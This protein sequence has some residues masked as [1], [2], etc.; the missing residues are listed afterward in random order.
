MTALLQDIDAAAAILRRGGTVAFATETVFGLGA[1]FDD[2]AAVQKVFSAKG[3]PSDNPLIVHVTDLEDIAGVAAQVTDSAQ[4]FLARFA[5]GPL[6]VVLPR[7]PMV[8]DIVA[9]GLPTVAVRLPDHPDARRL[10]RA[11]GVPLVAPSANRSGRPSPTTWQA[12]HE[13]LDGRIDAILIGMPTRIGLESTVV[14]CT[15]QPP[16][17]LRAGA[18][19]LE[20]LQEVIPETVP[21]VGEGTAEEVLPSPGMRHRHY[22]PNARVLLVDRPLR[23][24]IPATS[25]Y[26][27]LDPPG[28]TC[29]EGIVKQYDDVDGYARGLFAAFREA[30]QRGVTTIY[31]QRVCS[32]G[33]GRALMDRLERAA[34]G[35][36][37]PE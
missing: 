32:Q 22:C 24:D 34:E 33:I 15:R 25:M 17:M 3:R 27:G 30:D 31:C 12:V 28:G 20:Q 23:V 36:P 10:I 9:A 5:P 26:L 14:D 4:A 35:S 1:R 29:H 2:T 7:G 19:G 8:V 16:V 6:T 18:V 13:D 37:S 21:F 11:A